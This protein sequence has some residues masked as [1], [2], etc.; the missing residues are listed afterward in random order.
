MNKI[1]VIESE[2]K[3]VF[4]S[5]EQMIQIK[6]LYIPS[7][8]HLRSADVF[9]DKNIFAET[10]DWVFHYSGS[11][12]HINFKTDDYT[13]KLI[14]YILYRYASSKSPGTIYR[15]HRAWLDAIEYAS[16][17][18]MFNFKLLSSFLE[19]ENLLPT[20]FFCIVFGLKILCVDEFPGFTLDDYEDLEL[21][22]RPNSNDWN[23]YQNI[24]NILDPFEKNMISKGLFEMAAA[25]SRGRKYNLVDLRNATV[26]G[27]SYVTGSRPVQLA[28]LAA[29]DFR[30]DTCNTTT[31]LVRYSVL[32]PYAKQRH[33]TTD[34]LIL[35]LPPEI[36]AL[37]KHYIDEARLLPTDKMFNMGG[38]APK[39]VSQSISQT[40]LS[41]SPQDYQF[42]VSC[43]EAAL[44]SITST[45]LRHNVGHSLAMQGASAEEIAH[46][47]GHSSL[48]VAKHYIRATPALALI[49]AKALG[50]NP[51]WQNMVAM[52]LTGKLVPS[53]E[54][55]GRR[56]VGMV[57]DR[58]HY[59]IG[60]CARTDD[61]CPFCEV[62][63]CYG[64]LYYRP[65]LDG[66]HQGVLNSVSK[67]VDELIA[68]SDS[69][70]N[71]LNPLISIHETT[72]IEI[73]S[74][75]AR[76]HLHNVRGCGK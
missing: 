18:G 38:S 47:L 71:A 65:F 6:S 45:D 42:A 25:I 8:I 37:V 53:K 13:T 30:I 29:G 20:Y 56:V 59:E 72:Q 12:S 61:E 69:V 2:D 63:C 74:V 7:K 1:P 60:G 5:R 28:K 10:N 40:I 48:V 23:V 26:L 3:H 35:A 43:G 14:K 33:V 76:C 39:F 21:I 75:I 50:S 68:V 11:Q 46:I 4:F 16:K 32:L 57:G 51:V 64:C 70:G 9:D 31:G 17:Q 73:K 27:L 52:M 49:R 34:R 55:E 67:E 19:N 58:L 54:W 44:P 62:R 24:D 22:P 15:V 36:G 66:H 41:F